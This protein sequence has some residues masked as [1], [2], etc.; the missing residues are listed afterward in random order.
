MVQLLPAIAVFAGIAVGSLPRGRVMA[1]GVM[2]ALA[3]ATTPPFDFLAPMLHEAQWDLEKSVQRRKITDYLDTNYGGERILISM[4]ALAHFMHETSAAGLDVRDYIHEGNGGI[5]RRA[6]DRPA[7]HAGWIVVKADD[8][9]RRDRLLPLAQSRSDF[10]D[11]FMK[12]AE[13]GGVALY[14]RQATAGD[15]P[16]PAGMPD[17]SR[18]I[19]SESD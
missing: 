10:L 5:W 12:V 3:V 14:R 18:R 7:L 15:P 11:G 17:M 6:L 4:G 8:V 13:S 19:N 2:A 16:R 9:Q 1:A